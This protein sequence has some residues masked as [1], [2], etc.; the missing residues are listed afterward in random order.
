MQER[1]SPWIDGPAVCCQQLAHPGL[2]DQME[3]VSVELQQI[4]RWKTQDH[5]TNIV[6]KSN[7]EWAHG[8]RMCVSTLRVQSRPFR[9]VRAGRNGS[10]RGPVQWIALPCKRQRDEVADA[11]EPSATIQRSD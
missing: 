7:D 2:A 4:Q 8:L 11:R 9:S 5:V 6:A 10:V 1:T 3:R